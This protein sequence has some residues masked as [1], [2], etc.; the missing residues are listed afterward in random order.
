MAKVTRQISKN[1]CF[2]VVLWV[3]D[4]ALSL[5]L[6]TIVTNQNDLNMNLL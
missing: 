2:L 6:G 5:P 1:R 4:L 3:K